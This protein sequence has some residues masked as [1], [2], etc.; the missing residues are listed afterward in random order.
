VFVLGASGMLGNAMLRLLADSDRYE[1]WGSVRSQAKREYL[2]Q[3]LRER[4][5]C[6]VDVE[7][8]DRLTQLFCDVKPD[9]VINCVGLVKQLREAD[10]PLRAIQINSLLPHRLARLCQIAGARL[11]HISTDCVFAGTKGMYKEEDCADAQD[12]YGRSKYLGEVD[13]PNAVTLRTSI[14]GHE[15]TGAHGL[16][17]W[18][19]AQ[20]GSVSGFTK[21]VFS[22]LPTVEL[23]RVIRDHV[24]PRSQLHGL[25]HVSAAPISKYE[26]LRLV[27]QLY[28]RHTRIIPDDE[29]VIDRSLDSS[30]FRELT[31][32]APAAWPELLGAMHR[33]G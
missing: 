32:Y 21:A 3:S 20:S 30:R 5:I 16:I 19:L 9:V 14:V 8:H 25:Y 24:L 10:D 27:G 2:P 1:A 29:L 26:L 6:D 15:L 33:F 17:G 7:H 11:V 28:G 13:Y 18:F 22:G 4:V 12:L 23:A 31:G